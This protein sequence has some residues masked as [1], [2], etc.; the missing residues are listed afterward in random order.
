MMP[1]DLLLCIYLYR[2]LTTLYNHLMC[3][4]SISIETEVVAIRRH[5]KY[6]NELLLIDLH[7]SHTPNLKYALHQLE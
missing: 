7:I 4:A 3:T 2:C 6:K 5:A 1:Y